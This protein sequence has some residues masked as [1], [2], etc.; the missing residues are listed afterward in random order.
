MKSWGLRPLRRGPSRAV[1]DAK[2]S[3]SAQLSNPVQRPGKPADFSRIRGNFRWIRGRAER[4]GASVESG[5]L[6]L[7]GEAF[8]ALGEARNLPGA[9]ISVYN[10]LRGGARG[11]RLGLT[12]RALGCLNVARSQRFLYL[13]PESAHPRPP[14]LV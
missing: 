8:D 14:R 1:R 13:P 3:A 10:A 5:F 11:L 4:R 6:S 9:Q 12:E 7:S 2:F